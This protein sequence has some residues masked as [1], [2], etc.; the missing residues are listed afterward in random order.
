MSRKMKKFVNLRKY[1]RKNLN[2]NKWVDVSAG[3][4]LGYVLPNFMPIT[5]ISIASNTV[6]PSTIVGEVIVE[7]YV[8]FKQYGVPL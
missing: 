6:M 2:V 1:A 7:R 8:R 3:T 4:H 5:Q